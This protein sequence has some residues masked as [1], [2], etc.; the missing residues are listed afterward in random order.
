MGDTSIQAAQRC[1]KGVEF[2][3][4]SFDVCGTIG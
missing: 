3:N 1:S 2:R 4:Q